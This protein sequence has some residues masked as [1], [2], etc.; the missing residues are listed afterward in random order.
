V[1]EPADNGQELWK[2]DGTAAGTVQVKGTTPGMW[3]SFIE[4]LFAF[5]GQLY[6]RL[7]TND[8]YELWRTDG[9]D[10]GTVKV[11]QLTSTNK[12]AVFSKYVL[13]GDKFYFTASD[14]NGSYALWTSDG[15]EAGTKVVKNIPVGS[16]YYYTRDILMLEDELYFFVQNQTGFCALWKSDGTEAGTAFYADGAYISSDAFVLDDVLY[17][18]A[19]QWNQDYELWKAETTITDTEDEQQAG[20]LT[21]YPNPSAGILSVTLKNSAPI[22]SIS[23]IDSHGRL[24]EHFTQPGVQAILNIGRL[25]TGVYVLIVKT[26][27]G[28]YRTRF[29]KK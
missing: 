7:T 8:G 15:T 17:F 16:G 20:A 5:E 28:V 24:A 9:T 11:K 22:T 10:A 23:I 25:Q 14:Y 12:F 1:T 27:R 21:L 3:L 26:D 4:G 2:T 18:Q 19:D 29:V 6:F 13:L